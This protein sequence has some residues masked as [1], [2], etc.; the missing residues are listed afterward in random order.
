MFEKSEDVLTQTMRPSPFPLERGR[1][2]RI[3]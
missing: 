3:T 1:S 2:L